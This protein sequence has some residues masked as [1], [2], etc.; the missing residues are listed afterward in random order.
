M[1]SE[2][3]VLAGQSTFYPQRV[4]VMGLS[5][6]RPACSIIAYLVFAVTLKVRYYRIRRP[7]IAYMSAHLVPYRRASRDLGA[8]G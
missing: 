5:A 2:G 6:D 1:K 3:A 7:S 8:D 4:A